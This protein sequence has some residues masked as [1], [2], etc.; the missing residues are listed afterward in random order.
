MPR[1]SRRAA[2][3]PRVRRRIIVRGAVQGVGF[4]P[5]I[6]RQAV[7]LGLAGWVSNTS[8]GVLIEA[9]GG[10]TAIAGLLHA[11]RRSAPSI[12]RVDRVSVRPTAV[13]GDIGFTVRSSEAA[14]E[15]ATQILPDIATCE[16]C[17]SEMQHPAD[18]RYRYPFISCTACG[19]RYSI[20]QDL[21]YDRARTSMRHFI[22]C[23][24]CQREYDDPLDR[25]FHSEP[26]A[27]PVCGPS[28]ALCDPSGTVSHRENAALLA[29]AAAIREG[30]I[31]AV[32]GIGGYHLLADA[33]DED[34]VRRLRMRKRRD[35]K[36]FAVM[37]P[38]LDAVRATCRLDRAEE[39][40][41]TGVERPIVLVRYGRGPIAPA[42]APD[43]ARLGVLLPYSPLHHLLMQ[44]LATP[45]VA[46]SGNVSDE[47]IVTN[48]TDALQRLAD[49]ADVFLVHDR[50]ILRPV[51]DS[52]AQVVCGRPQLLRRARGYAPAPVPTR[53]FPE[54]ILAFGSH[55]KSTVALS[56]RS[57]VTV[58]Q[59]LGDLGSA[60]GRELHRNTLTDLIRTH[61]P[62]PRL[63][64][65][66]LHPD[67]ASS[68]AAERS[69][70]PLFTVQHHVAHVAACLAEH[71][72][73]PPALGVAWDGT[74][75]GP[76]G[77]IWGGEFLLLG[78]RGWRRVARLR[79]FLL[80]GGE[81]AVR[82]P[83][84]AALGL[85]YTAFGLD[86]L[87]RFDLPPVSAF[88]ATELRALRT[89]LT[90]RVNAPRTSSAGRLF[91]AWAALC[92]LRQ[93]MSHDG[94]AA[95]ALERAACGAD[96]ETPCEFPVREMHGESPALTLD[97]EPALRTL[98][99]ARQAGTPISAISQGFHS[100]LAA[101]IVAVAE[102]V[103]ER[104]V[105]L[106][107]GCF[108]NVRLTE[109]AVGSLAAA[110]FEPL[111][112]EQIP[113]NDGGI[114]FGQV[115]WASWAEAGG[116]TPCA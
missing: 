42:V 30:G 36:P 49:L 10:T 2:T 96:R 23:T 83:R 101:A 67:Y 66:D 112:H 9:E 50:P 86:C 58:S 47:P 56:D 116:A 95:M 77:T 115:A 78:N 25:R 104:R 43:A 82:E 21:P 99:S 61:H 90:R 75:Y 34:V 84:R 105:V 19:P 87:E 68:L 72:L 76:D 35:G 31:V 106:T 54:G 74:G 89:V 24:D 22:M 44:E 62:R 27:C 100:G 85:L 107:G 38:S 69:G 65:R 110:G 11:I 37:F 97:W 108:Q 46:T 98:L 71:G 7:Q 29:A 93:R 40:L 57:G 79:P 94:Q 53:G 109:A 81:A 41:L 33:G 16:A 102:R 92:G 28:L 63:A 111:W 59:H 80:P 64:V 114:A 18:R 45:V 17:I 32:K 14:G 73:A 20:V 51:D 26:N 103:G 3:D 12:A 88:S 4:R 39:T 13:R 60:A 70:L 5:F 52:V 48:E 113:P 15:P 8:A 6:Y 55:L 91:D 1:T